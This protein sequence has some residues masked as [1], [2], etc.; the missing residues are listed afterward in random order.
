MFDR[1]AHKY[2]MITTRQPQN[3][4]RL[5]EFSLLI[6]TPMFNGTSMPRSAR[7]TVEKNVHCPHP[8]RDE[9]WSA[10]ELK[11]WCPPASPTNHSIPLML[12]LHEYIRHWTFTYFCSSRTRLVLRC[13]DYDSKRAT[14]T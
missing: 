6:S 7:I 13:P 3:K 11:P 9:P 8:V 12:T 1:V 10:N 14:M 4:Y 5:M 2:A